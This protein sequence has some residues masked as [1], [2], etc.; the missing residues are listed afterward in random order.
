MNA[1]LETKKPT[2]RDMYNGIDEKVVTPLINSLY[3]PDD[4]INEK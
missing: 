1:P 2:Y 3:R 4:L